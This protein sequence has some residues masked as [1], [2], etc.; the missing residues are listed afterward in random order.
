MSKRYFL[1]NFDTFLGKAIVAELL[2]E[3]PDEPTLMCTYKDASK[4]EKPKGFKKILKRE[5]PKLFR[6]KM[7]EECDVYIYDLNESPASDVN[8]VVEA[9]RNASLEE[10]KVLVIVSNIMV[11]AQTPRKEKPP[12]PP[13]EETQ[14]NPE[15]NNAT[16]TQEEEERKGEDNEKEGEGNQ[17]NE[18]NKENTENPEEM[19]V[20][21]EPPKE[22]I[23]FTEEHY[24]DRVSHPDYQTLKDLEDLCL[25]LQKENLK[26]IVVCAGVLYGQGEIFLHSYFQVKIKLFIYFKMFSV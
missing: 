16:N 6:K 26:V 19:P 21:V 7:L 1:N 8:F 25:S 5:K 9:L 13:P 2:K 23:P 3:I 12:P 17:E 4:V 15:G 20:P 18:E 10:S 22:Y 14:D 24:K 11:W